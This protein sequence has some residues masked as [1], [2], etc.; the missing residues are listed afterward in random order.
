MA[1]LK[2]VTS[3][4][5]PLFLSLDFLI[6]EEL[7]VQFSSVTQGLISQSVFSH[8]RPLTYHSS[9]GQPYS[10]HDYQFSFKSHL[11]VITPDGLPCPNKSIIIPIHYSL[12]QNSI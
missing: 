7:S 9:Y 6:V 10:S 3:A 8:L 1:L 2:S 11:D 12:S 5:S 4:R